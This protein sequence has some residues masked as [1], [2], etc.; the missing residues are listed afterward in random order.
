MHPDCGW[1]EGVGGWK[2]ESTPVLAIFIGSFRWACNDVVPP[3]RR[4]MI[5]LCCEE[6]YLRIE[7]QVEKEKG[8]GK[9]TRALTRG[10]W[11][12]TDERLCMEEDFVGWFG[13]RA[14]TK[15][16]KIE[17]H[18]QGRTTKRKVLFYLPL[19]LP[20]LRLWNSIGE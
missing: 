17:D 2:Q 11:S 16:C 20:F 6:A 9:L 10:Y 1:C 12:Q 4:V 8:K 14:L 15:R 7:G 19:E 13:T 5:S 3:G 18:G